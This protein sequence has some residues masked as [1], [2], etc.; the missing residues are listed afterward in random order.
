MLKFNIKIKQKI[1]K[2][3]FLKTI[4]NLIEGNSMATIYMIIYV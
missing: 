4:C 3:V 1:K 2:N